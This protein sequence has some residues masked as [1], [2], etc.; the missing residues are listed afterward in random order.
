MRKK[1]VANMRK[2]MWCSRYVHVGQID[3]RP[4]SERLEVAGC[5]KNGHICMGLQV[6]AV[7]GYEI[8]RSVGMR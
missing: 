3:M 4:N 7:G 6:G 2:V 5:F 1:K 8:R